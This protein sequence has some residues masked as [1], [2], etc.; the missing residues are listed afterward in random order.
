M[1]A[2]NSNATNSELNSN[3][4]RNLENMN[5]NCSYK[6]N[7][8]NRSNVS[9]KQRNIKEGS[10]K[11]NFNN[12]LLTLIKKL[13]SPKNPKSHN[14]SYSEV[15]SQAS[16]R[17]PVPTGAHPPKTGKKS[18]MRSNT[19]ENAHNVRMKI[20]PFQDYNA[21]LRTINESK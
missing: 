1:D 13:H 2:M 6:R 18:H 8:S 3:L 15:Y 12:Q 16:K 9:S 5:P 17:V 4:Y 10:K 21:A 20:H 11:N 19:S 7:K 14:H